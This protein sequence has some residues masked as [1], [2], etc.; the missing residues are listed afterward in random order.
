MAI[1]ALGYLGIRSDKREEW[2]AFASGLLGMQQVDRCGKTLAFRMDDRKQRLVV[3]DEPGETL[4]FMGWEVDE[5]RDLE[6]YA[7]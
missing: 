7:V 5:R 2:D 3:S 6:Q 1:K 4:A